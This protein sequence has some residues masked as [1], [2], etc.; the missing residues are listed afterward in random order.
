[1]VSGERK[2][3]RSDERGTRAVERRHLNGRLKQLEKVKLD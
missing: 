3:M 2:G 1:L